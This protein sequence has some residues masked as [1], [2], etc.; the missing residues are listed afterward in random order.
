[1]ETG[2][3]GRTVLVTG[4]ASGIGLACV[5]SFAA[6]G[7]RV[8]CADINRPGAEAAAAE[9]GGVAAVA[10]V[11]VAANAAAL[12][13]TAIERTGQ[14]DV[15][16][17][18]HGV[19]SD[20]P[21]LE[22]G[23]EEWDRLHA[24]N[25]RGT[26]LMAQAALTVMVPR[27]RG[28]IVTIA[29]LAGQ[30][31]GLHAGAAYASSKAGVQAL[32]KSLARIAGPHGITVNCVNPGFIETPMTENWPAEASAEVVKSTSLGRIGTAGDVAAA[33]V[34]L[35]SDAASFVH[36]AHLDVNGGLHMD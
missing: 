1:M 16:V 30:L 20:T 22:I 5:R 15:L 19:F 36:G 25:L 24:V 33:V 13:A 10:D 3:N 26:F 32:T 28:R 14:L 8:V 18:S 9:V 2:L 21:L 6:E 34:W 17:T 7:A 4:A 12:A 23:T 35:A 11:T 31:G 27:E 29:S